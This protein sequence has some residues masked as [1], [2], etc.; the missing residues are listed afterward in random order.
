MK[1]IVILFLMFFFKQENKE[2]IY[3]FFPREN[4]FFF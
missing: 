1:R 3:K 2:K 4:F